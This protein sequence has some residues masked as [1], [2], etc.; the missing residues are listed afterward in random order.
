MSVAEQLVLELGP[1]T[2]PVVENPNAH[3]FTETGEPRRQLWCSDDARLTGTCPYVGEKTR[4]RPNG[5]CCFDLE[6]RGRGI[7][8]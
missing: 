5:G 2:P 7:P 1:A 3:F 8:Y 6:G 4:F